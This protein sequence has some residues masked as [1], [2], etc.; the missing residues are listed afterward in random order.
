M[1]GRRSRRTLLPP[2]RCLPFV[3]VWE[4]A[5]KDNVEAEMNSARCF[6]HLAG[7]ALARLGRKDEAVAQWEINS[8]RTFWQLIPWPKKT[9][10]NIRTTVDLRHGPC[11]FMLATVVAAGVAGDI[12]R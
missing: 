10:T 2:R 3:E 7:V 8:S 9:L 6:F 11:P 4:Q 5:P 12:T 1:C